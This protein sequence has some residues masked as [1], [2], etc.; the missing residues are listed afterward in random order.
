MVDTLLSDDIFA[1]M[2]R[3]ETLFVEV[4]SRVLMRAK[5]EEADYMKDLK[6]SFVPK[7]S[8]SFGFSK[9]WLRV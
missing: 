1:R 3:D 2:I 8:K 9:L 4:Y 7:D 5:N 6:A